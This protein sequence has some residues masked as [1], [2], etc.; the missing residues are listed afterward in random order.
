MKGLTSCQLHRV[1]S[2][3]TSQR[4]II[5]TWCFMPS[6][7]LWLYQG[8]FSKRKKQKN[9]SDSVSVIMAELSDGGIGGQRGHLPRHHRYQYQGRECST[10]GQHPT[11][12][13]MGSIPGRSSR[14]IF[15]SPEPRSCT[16]SYF[17]ICST[18]V[19]PQQHP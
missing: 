16:D 4:I 9:N 1:T 15:F 8:D 7:P 10:V 19:L 18:P 3:Q 6:Q 5:I 13:H 12:D 11:H 14:T 2:G 17:C